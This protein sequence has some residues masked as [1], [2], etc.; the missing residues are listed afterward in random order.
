MKRFDLTMGL[1]KPKQ[2]WLS[3]DENYERFWEVRRKILDSK[4][5][6][7]N[8]DKYGEVLQCL[9]GS[10]DA[11]I[12]LLEVV[13]NFLVKTYP[14]KFRFRGP[15]YDYPLVSVIPVLKTM[16]GEK[17]AIENRKSGELFGLGEW[18][19]MPPMEI[20]ARLCSEDFN[21]LKKD[22]E[23]QH[24]LIASAT[25]FPAGWKLKERIGWTVTQLHEK[26][27]SWYPK[28]SQPVEH[29]FDRLN[30][31]NCMERTTYFIQNASPWR[32]FFSDLDEFLFIQE[33]KDFLSGVFRNLTPESII[34]RH[35]RQ[36]FTRLPKSD[37]VLFTVNTSLVPLVDLTDE[38]LDGLASE[39]CSW[40]HATAR[41][42][43]RDLWGEIVVDFC[44]YRTGIEYTIPDTP[45]EVSV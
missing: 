38:Q 4:D 5:R 35:E 18:C 3:H 22:S 33:G 12:E 26:V 40:P 20:V 7:G 9:P 30:E 1:R 11:C 21:I 42:R 31:E 23:G 39:I 34:V 44:T 13:T 32:T 19:D 14:S 37:T 17:R 10:E 16:F 43:G 41:Y 25:L 45:L 28:L 15:M 6:K 2:R 8:R 24:R 29:Y 27:P 36:T